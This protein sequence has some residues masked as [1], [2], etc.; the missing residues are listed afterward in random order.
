MPNL[1]VIAESPEELK[2]SIARMNG[3]SYS[4]DSINFNHGI[5]SPEELEKL[6]CQEPFVPRNLDAIGA[7]LKKSHNE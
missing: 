3:P 7:L 2:K 1:A 5:C 6:V 4:R